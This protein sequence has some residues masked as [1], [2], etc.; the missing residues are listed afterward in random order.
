MPML[1]LIYFQ[2]VGFLMGIP[3]GYPKGLLDMVK[4]FPGKL[5][6]KK[7]EKLSKDFKHLFSR[8]GTEPITD[9]LINE[10]V[11]KGWSG[12][13]LKKNRNKGGKYSRTRNSII[14]PP[15]FGSS[16]DL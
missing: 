14:Y 1:F 12:E 8:D 16:E 5:K 7:R 9:E 6:K 13:D 4:G 11:E 2:L 3:V 10:L 15:D